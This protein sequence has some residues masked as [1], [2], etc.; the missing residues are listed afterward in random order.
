MSGPPKVGMGELSRMARKNSPAAPKCHNLDTWLAVLRDAARA[1]ALCTR[2]FVIV[3]SSSV[4]LFRRGWEFEGDGFADK[5][6]FIVSGNGGKTKRASLRN[7]RLWGGGQY[8]YAGGRLFAPFNSSYARAPTA[9]VS[10]AGMALSS[11]LALG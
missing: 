7:A 2:S 5:P 1:A 3:T 4:L 10:A 9:A 6:G 8:A 11:P